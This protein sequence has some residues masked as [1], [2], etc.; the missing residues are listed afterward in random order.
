MLYRLLREDESIQN[1]LSAKNVDAKK[2]VFAH[3]LIGSNWEWESQYISTCG[4]MKAVLLLD[5]YCRDR[6]IVKI[7]EKNLP[8][9]KIDLR[10]EENRKMYFMDRKCR[11]QILFNK[12]A[13]TRDEVLLVGHVPETHVELLT[14]SDIRS[15]KLPIFNIAGVEDTCTDNEIQ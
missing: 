8:V 15:G 10:T 2:S 11:D 5:P 1:G 14:D 7:W 6:R 4:S 13:K 12:Y 9:I 3:V